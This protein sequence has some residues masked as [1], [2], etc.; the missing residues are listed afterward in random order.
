MNYL[1][2]LTYAHSFLLQLLPTIVV[3]VFV[4][5]VYTGLLGVDGFVWGFFS[6]TIT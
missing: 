3:V 1:T 4:V 5:V 2:D 6:L